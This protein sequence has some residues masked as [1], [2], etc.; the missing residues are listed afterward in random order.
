MKEKSRLNRIINSWTCLPQEKVIILSSY[1]PVSLTVGQNLTSAVR[2]EAG[3]KIPVYEM[4]TLMIKTRK[5][6]R[7]KKRKYE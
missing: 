1:C 3:T 4:V 6:T 5:T 7:R 2:S